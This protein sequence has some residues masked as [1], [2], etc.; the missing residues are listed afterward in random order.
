[1]SLTGQ[2][3]RERKQEREVLLSLREARVS[4]AAEV[5][6]GGSLKPPEGLQ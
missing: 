4:N 2:K 5:Q 1:M 6:E 3:E